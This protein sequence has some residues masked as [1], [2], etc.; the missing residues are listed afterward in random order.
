MAKSGNS[1]KKHSRKKKKTDDSDKQS[2]EEVP[3]FP[4]DKPKVH[5]MSEEDLAKMATDGVAHKELLSESQSHSQESAYRLE[6]EYDRERLKQLQET[7]VFSREKI[8]EFERQIS[9][10]ESRFYVFELGQNIMDMS[11]FLANNLRPQIGLGDK[12]IEHLNSDIGKLQ[13]KRGR[14][15]DKKSID[16]RVEKIE[17][18]IVQVKDNQKIKQEFL[19]V[20]EQ[21]KDPSQALLNY[22]N[23]LQAKEQD[24]QTEL[25]SY[26]ALKDSTERALLDAWKT[27]KPHSAYPKLD[28][29]IESVA[30]QAESPDE[31]SASKVIDALSSFVEL[32]IKENKS[33]NGLEKELAKSLKKNSEY[34][35]LVK[36]FKKK[37]AKGGISA[38]QFDKL[39]SGLKDDLRKTFDVYGG[40]RQ[41]RERKAF[42]DSY[43]G[44]KGLKK[45]LQGYE[46][47]GDW[48]LERGA[49]E[50]IDKAIEKA[51]HLEKAVKQNNELKRAKEEAELKSGRAEERINSLEKIAQSYM[52]ET[53]IVKLKSEEYASLLRGNAALT[54]NLADSSRKLADSN[55]ER[56]ELKAKSRSAQ[57]REN[58]LVGVRNRAYGVLLDKSQE[59]IDFYK[60]DIDIGKSRRQIE[61][62]RELVKPIGEIRPRLE[63]SLKKYIAEQSAKPED[64]RNNRRLERHQEH[65]E[66]IKDMHSTELRTVLGERLREELLKEN[67]VFNPSWEALVGFYSDIESKSRKVHGEKIS[68]IEGRIETLEEKMRIAGEEYEAREKQLKEDYEERL[69]ARNKALMETIDAKKKVDGELAQVKEGYEN[70]KQELE[71]VCNAWEIYVKGYNGLQ[72][73]NLKLEN[74]LGKVINKAKGYFNRARKA[75]KELHSETSAKKNTETRA[76]EL[77]K[78][79]FSEM[80]Q[81]IAL[82]EEADSLRKQL[83]EDPNTYLIENLKEIYNRLHELQNDEMQN[84][85]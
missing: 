16:A 49:K 62:Y 83:A 23:L 46:K 30:A 10:L 48:V 47:L 11:V 58:A 25:L 78:M 43:G 40:E 57:N 84:N 81:R 27:I 15:K 50:G 38:K 13:K 26:Y 55:R 1:G 63:E 72:K 59:I 51:D 54:N 29:I 37:P 80:E 8:Q 28:E 24:Y 4:V 6:V 73:D 9:T 32:Y 22:F 44:M 77:Q 70:T 18:E 67:I 5:F 31:E 75:E 61:N 14:A 74:R 85:Q 19:D 12:Q 64:K 7:G 82:E 3:D 35:A 34:E 21:K 42:V 17:K 53:G 33:V 68:D 20:A 60:G 36:T 76:D 71:R 39:K 56:D 45:V 52:D 2:P 69:D 65:L 79:Y 41:I 66:R